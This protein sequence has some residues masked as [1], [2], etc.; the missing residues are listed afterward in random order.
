MLTPGV[1]DSIGYSFGVPGEE[2]GSQMK[3]LG[4]GEMKST[5]Q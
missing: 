1:I 4:I 3:T 5:S 2:T